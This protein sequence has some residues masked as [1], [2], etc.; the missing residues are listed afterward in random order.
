MTYS[1]HLAQEVLKQEQP[2]GEQRAGT[3]LPFEG[4]EMFAQCIEAGRNQ[5]DFIGISFKLKE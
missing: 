4:L 1:M 2:E 3:A 5:W